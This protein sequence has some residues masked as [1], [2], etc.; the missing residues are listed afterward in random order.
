MTLEYLGKMTRKVFNY[1]RD[2]MNYILAAIDEGLNKIGQ[3]QEQSFKEKKKNQTGL[4]MDEEKM[5][6]NEQEVDKFFN[7]GHDSSLVIGKKI[8]RGRKKRKSLLLQK[9]APKKKPI[10]ERDSD[11]SIDIDTEI[12]YPEGK[13]LAIILANYISWAY[14]YIIEK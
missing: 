7:E 8:K 13:K 12:E 5:N 11:E 3:K 4:M 6:D 10:E 1:C 2:N 14:W 9:R